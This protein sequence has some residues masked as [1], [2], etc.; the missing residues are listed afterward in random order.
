MDMVS[1][2]RSGRKISY[3]TIGAPAADPFVV[4]QVPPVILLPTMSVLVKIDGTDDRDEEWRRDGRLR[5]R[6]RVRKKV[7][8]SLLGT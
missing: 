7:S 8:R 2:L 4:P 3:T 6:S 5:S 1:A